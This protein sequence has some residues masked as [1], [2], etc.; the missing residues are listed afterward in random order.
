[1]TRNVLRVSPMIKAWRLCFM[2]FPVLLLP[3][4]SAEQVYGSAQQMEQSRCSEGPAINYQQC[5]EQS[6]MSYNEY[7]RRRAASNQEKP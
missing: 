6:G 5:L 2:L 7:K 3:A 4:C 1:V